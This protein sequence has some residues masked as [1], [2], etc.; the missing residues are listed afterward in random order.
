MK[1]KR[2][3]CFGCENG[4]ANEDDFVVEYRAE[5]GK[6]IELCFSISSN[7][8]QWYKVDGVAYR[9][10]KEAKQACEVD[11]E[12]VKVMGEELT[13]KLGTPSEYADAYRLMIEIGTDIDTLNRANHMGLEKKLITLEHFQAAAKV[14]AAE[15]LKR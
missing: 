7:S 1:Y 2:I 8:S 13:G 9:T 15:I 4:K 3:Y 10:L 12:K 6:R 5:N 14:L 11:Q